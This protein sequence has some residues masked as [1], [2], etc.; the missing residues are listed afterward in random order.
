MPCTGVAPPFFRGREYIQLALNTIDC[1]RSTPSL[2][3]NRDDMPP[4]LETRKSM[5]QR[6]ID[7]ARERGTPIDTN[8]AFIDLLDLWVRGE[9]DFD[10]LRGHY[11]DML[12]TQV[13]ERRG[14]WARGTSTIETEAVDLQ[15]GADGQEKKG[16]R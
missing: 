13:R 4:D 11:D 12:K 3:T 6:V 10:E 14:R 8:P 9:I 5:A 16:Q 7:H 1:Y 15:S 2:N